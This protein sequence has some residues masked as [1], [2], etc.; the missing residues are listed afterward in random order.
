MKVRVFKSFAFV[1]VLLFSLN[2]VAGQTVPRK[3]Q[4]GQE[5]WRSFKKAQN[6]YESNDY[7]KAIEYAE[8]ARTIR[9]QDAAWQTYVLEN[10]LKKARVRRAGDELD[11]VLPELKDL[12]FNDAV[13]IIDQHT[14]KLGVGYFNNSY[15]KVFDY[16]SIYSHYTEADYLLGKVYRLEGE[17]EVALRYM[18]EAYDCAVNLDVPMEKYDLLYD[19]A[20]LSFDLGKYDDFEKYLLAIVMDNEYYSDNA[21]MRSLK[22][23]VDMDSQDAVDKFF[24]LYRC[25]ND[26]ALKALIDLSEIYRTVGETDK[27]LKC[28]SLASII[29]VSKLEDIISQR[30]NDFEFHGIGDLLIKCQRYEDIVTW[31]NENNIWKLFCNFAEAAASNGKIV[32]ARNLLRILSQYEP[33]EYWRRYASE[34]IVN[35]MKINM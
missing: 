17:F 1:L 5:A 23:I 33:E 22:R 29:A 14:E 2:S 20:S 6:A 34:I 28:S 25:D 15:S 9:K 8:E 7:S 27:T 12:G 13:D 26:L 16:I 30:I 31:G 35:G 10:T 3:V 4:K 18:K 21:F 24:L 19:L 32:F 11:R